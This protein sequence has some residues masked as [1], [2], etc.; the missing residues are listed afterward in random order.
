[1]IL[2]QAEAVTG[3]KVNLDEIHVSLFKGI[4]AK[5]LSVKER[6]GQK[7]FL[8]VGNLSSPINFYLF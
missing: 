8:K 6:D 2:P 5:G 4:V 3:R 1:M 7:D